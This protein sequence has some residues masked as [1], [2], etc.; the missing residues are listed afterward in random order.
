MYFSYNRIRNESSPVEFQL[1]E[2]EVANIDNLINFGQ[3][4]YNWNSEGK[5]F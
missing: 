1:V 4:R 3:E 2:E 5:R